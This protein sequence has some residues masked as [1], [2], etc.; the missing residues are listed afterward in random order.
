M[1]TFLALLENE[2]LKLLRRRRP[3]LVLLVLAVFLTIA[4]WAA[5]RQQE[6]RARNAGAADWRPRVEQRIQDTERRANRR[7]IFVGFSRSLRFEAVR[8]RYHL[9][10]GI[11]PDRQTGPLWAR[12]FAALAS[13]LLL[14][15]LVT[16][17]AAD[18]VSSES[19]A[20]TIKMLLTRP[21][22]RWKIFA[23]KLAAMALFTSLLVAAS[24][25]LAW[26]I[27]GFAFGWKGF[28]APVLTGFRFGPDG[29]D[30][31]AVRV[32][33]LW[34]DTLAAYGLAWLSA[35]ATGAIAVTFSTL[36]RTTAAAMG[37]LF[38]L[39]VSGT[40]LGQ[41]ATD[42]EPTRW[43]FVTNLPLAQFYSGSP[44]PVA[45]MTLGHSVAVL[46][47]WAAA[48]IA[49]GGFVFDRRDVTA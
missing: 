9:E 40:L 3:Q 24:A 43:M 29:V 48:A 49:V 30:L 22:S 21:V 5:H 6:D 31:S 45:G 33:P 16:L 17:L 39:I 14:P 38:A 27:A 25:L 15:L 32:A 2:S 41:M 44:P 47:V 1:R 19:R 46:V 26:L 4:T 37:T 13:A 8:L 10:R 18:Q 36:F 34:L 23:S 12:T 42:W 7:R 28:G 35:L 11:D 20:G